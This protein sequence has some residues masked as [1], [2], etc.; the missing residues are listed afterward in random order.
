MVVG[1][2]WEAVGGS[3]EQW[4]IV[5]SSGGGGES[6]PEVLPLWAWAAAL[7]LR[8]DGVGDP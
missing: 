7:G 1:R 4:G 2:R 6:G 3:G 8:T 5:G